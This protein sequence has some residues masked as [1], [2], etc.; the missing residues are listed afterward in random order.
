MDSKSVHLLIYSPK[1]SKKLIK[2]QVNL[3]RKSKLKRKSIE[4]APFSNHYYRIKSNKEI[5]KYKIISM[6]Y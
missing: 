1:R 5:N 3:K 2:P 6:N 4:Q